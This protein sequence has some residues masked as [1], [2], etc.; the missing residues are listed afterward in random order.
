M[1]CSSWAVCPARYG[2]SR[3][4]R[5]ALLLLLLLLLLLP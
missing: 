4:R 3:G 1:T 2:G 5:G